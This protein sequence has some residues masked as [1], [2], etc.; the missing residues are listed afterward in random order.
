M[1]TIRPVAWLCCLLILLGGVPAGASGETEGAISLQSFA[2]KRIGIMTGTVHDAYVK[3]YLP[4]AQRLYFSSV[5]DAV[6]ALVSGTIDAFSCENQQVWPLIA[7]NPQLTYLDEPMAYMPTA[8]VFAKSDSGKALCDQMD[9]FLEKL[10]AEGTLSA[11]QD[12]W[13]SVGAG[14]YDLDMNGL[15]GNARTLSF[16]TSCTGKPSVYYYNGKPTGYEVELAL[17]FCREYGYNMD[18]QLVDFA[19]IIPGV[20][21]GKYDFA[22]D[23]I[24]VTE[25]RK[26]SVNFSKPDYECAAVLVYRREDGSA[27]EGITSVAQLNQK[28]RKL[29][30]VTGMAVEDCYAGAAPLADIKYFNQ[31]SDMLFALSVGQIDGF[32]MDTPMIRYIA[33]T[34]PGVRMV[35]EEV[36]PFFDHAFILGESEFDQTLRVQLNEYIARIIEDGTLDALEALWLSPE[37][38]DTVID[39]PAEGKN[40]TVRVATETGAPPMSF[41]SNGKIAG[42]DMDILAHFCREYGYA[43]EVNDMA[44][45]SLLTSVSSGRCDIAGAFF[46]ITEERKETAIFSDAYTHCGMSF[47]V[48]EPVEESGFWD[49][50]AYSFH[51]TFIREARW[52]L[53]VQGIG[54]TV[55]ISVCSVILGTILGFGLCLARMNGNRAANGVISV[56]IRILQGT[57]VLVLLMILYYIIF[58]KTGMSGELVAIIAFALNFAAYSCEIFRSG[59]ESIDRGQM[60]AALAIGMKKSS[61]FFKIVLPQAAARFLPVYKGE[62]ISLVKMTS[63]VGY[64]AVQDLT[65][66]SDIIRSRTYEAFF[67]LISTAVIY[68]I[69][70]ALL[71]TL[72]KAVETRIGPR[73][74]ARILKGVKLS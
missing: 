16:A 25:E 65:K 49:R 15:D 32:A 34:N 68:F 38:A 17:M 4:N 30:I 9:A 1:K 37:G 35:N 36:G 5:G 62:F 64:I 21:T 27:D 20:T 45:A 22:A 8:F 72:L 50:L 74:S 63:V 48:R 14:D 66:M 69:L 11:L 13:M 6:T 54:V 71:T 10:E 2:D 67:P 73:R 26:Q 47:A 12:K 53:I 41:I 7:E 56:Y 51:R 60:D 52:K 28:G 70:S 31:L 3:E 46:S 29:G 39:Y 61:A 18:I 42:L 40:G 43:I 58:A 23:S 57:P 44:F 33:A 24:S 59:I 55:L 19:G